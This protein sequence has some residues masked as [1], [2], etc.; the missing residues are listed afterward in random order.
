MERKRRF[1]T[2]TAVLAAVALIAAACGGGGG[3]GGQDGTQQGGQ[4]ASAVIGGT[5][6]TEGGVMK[7][8]SIGDV[9]YMDPGA[10]YTVT[11]FSFI[12]RGALRGL[13]TYKSSPDFDT[14]IEVVPDLATSTGQANADNTQWTFELKD[15]VRFGPALGGKN[16]PGVTGQEITSQDIKYAIERLFNPS[17]GAG[18]A[19]YYDEIVGADKCEKAA[20]YGCEISGIKTPDPK[21]IVFNLTTPVGD[22]PYRMAMPATAPVPQSWA[23]R[24]DKQKDSDY[25]SNVV[26]SGPYYVD[27]Y[28]P[29]EQ[30]TLKKNPEWDP[31]TDD[32]RNAYVDQINWK[33]GF[34]NDVCVSK[35]ISGDYDLFVDCEPVGA[36]LKQVVTDPELNARFFNYGQ[37]CLNYIFINTTVKP[38]DDQ[39]VRQAVNLVVDKENQLKILG[40][41]YAGIIAPSILPPG[42]DGYLPPSEYAPLGGPTGEPN[43][44]EAKQLMEEAG[45]AN[46][47]PGKLLV[48]GES[49]DPGPKMMESLRADLKKIGIT[50]LEVKLL[51]YPDYYTQYYG[52]PRTNT[53]LGFSGWCEDFPDPVTFLEPL[54]YGPNILPH[55]NSNYSELDNPQ[56]N[57][58]IEEA[59]ALPLGPERT[60]KWEQA[61]KLAT[62]LAPWVPIRWYKSRL[63]VSPRMENAFY[64]AYYEHPD[65]VNAGVGGGGAS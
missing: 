49:E 56:L 44:A 59:L 62:E 39:K 23:S 6:P 25:D 7:W 37:P 36:S 29:E 12:N 10:A 47:F 55:A 14:A 64:H 13:T 32:V 21:T 33:Q 16:V 8:A 20:E 9:D 22:W 50:N 57:Q 27:S 60:Q 41:Q 43:V 40:G 54:L 31:A 15:G 5:S 2:L 48:V 53:A 4:D 11:Y 1:L 61:N 35:V 34:D 28:T 63:L 42:M 17:V 3:D 26:W 46:G 19:T 58:L 51:K 52:E 30:V 18:Y 24:F 38:F 45:Y 65:W